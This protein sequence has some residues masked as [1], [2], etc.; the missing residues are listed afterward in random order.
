MATAHEEKGVCPLLTRRD[1]HLSCETEASGVPLLLS[2]RWK[3][4]CFVSRNL[5]R[6]L[7]KP[8]C[9][10]HGAS[11]RDG[12]LWG[13]HFLK[14]SPSPL[15]KHLSRKVLGLLETGGRK[16]DAA[17]SPDSGNPCPRGGGGPG[18]GGAASRGRGAR[19]GRG[20]RASGNGPGGGGGGTGWEGTALLG[21]GSPG[22]KAG[23]P[24][25]NRARGRSEARARWWGPVWGAAR[26]GARD[27][28]PGCGPCGRPGRG[29]VTGGRSAPRPGG[30]P[31]RAQPP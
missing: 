27:P 9:Q 1:K 30:G 26:P 4:K 25:R 8:Q 6:R 2:L 13:I 15:Y 12:A 17:S 11:P 3:A 18:R 23:G 21:Q 19:G 16:L 20:G 22:S 28:S 31:A 14:G 5:V 7:W 24:R 10:I 29:R